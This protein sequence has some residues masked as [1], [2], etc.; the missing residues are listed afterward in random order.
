ML[1]GGTQAKSPIVLIEND[2]Y[3]YRMITASNG[4]LI[5]VTG[6]LWGESTGDWWIP[7]TKASDAELWCFLGYAPQQTVEQ[8]IET[9]VIWDTIALIM[10][11]LYWNNMTTSQWRHN[12]RYGVSSSRLFTLP[13]IQAQIKENIK[14]LRHWPLCGEITGHRWIPLT[15]G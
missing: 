13:F 14:A 6:P 10:T 8:T 7:L 11:S 4:N 5:R 9:S 3:H 15:K 1:F 2:E 12:E